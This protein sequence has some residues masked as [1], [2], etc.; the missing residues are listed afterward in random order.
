MIITETLDTIT[1]DSV[2]TNGIA[3]V[4]IVQQV[5]LTATTYVDGNVATSSS[6]FT[7][8]EDGY[9]M[10]TEIALTTT[11]GAGYYI[12]SGVVYNGGVEVTDLEDLLV[13]DL[14]MEDYD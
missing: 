13:T 3:Y 10:F 12:T 9:Y 14:T 5:S 4:H 6:S 2:P 7:F 1:L 11:P 8:T